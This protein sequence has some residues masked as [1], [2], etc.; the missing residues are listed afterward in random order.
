MTVEADIFTAIKGLVSNRAYPDLNDSTTITQPYIVY[1]QIGG[2]SVSFLER[3]NPSKKNGRYQISCWATTRAAAQALALQVE[4]AMVTASTF[5]A[6][7]IG[8]PTSVYDED[9][10]LRGSRQDFTVWSN[11]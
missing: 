2:E 11:R 10:K 7:P 9:T 6:K 3:A 5:D 1:Q 8:A 4:S